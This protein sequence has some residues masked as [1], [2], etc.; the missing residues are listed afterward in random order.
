MKISKP[1]FLLAGAGLGLTL[2]YSQQSSSDNSTKAQQI[3]RQ[4][5]AELN[6]PSSAPA[7]TPPGSLSPEARAKAQKILDE[8]LHQAANGQKP[9]APAPNTEAQSKAEQALQQKLNELR[10]GTASRPET[11]ADAQQIL[12]QK[13]AELNSAPQPAAAPPVSPAPV[14]KAKPAPAP[15]PA[16]PQIA[17]TVQPKPVEPQKTVAVQPK[18]APPK[19]AVTV[20]AKPAVVQVRP[21]PVV[22]QPPPEKTAEV[23]VAEKIDSVPSTPAPTLTPELDAKAREVLRMK[24][25]ESRAQ[26]PAQVEQPAPG[27][28]AAAQAA[29]NQNEAELKAGV[30]PDTTEQTRI[31]R[32][33]IAE[34][35]GIISHEEAT[36][37]SAPVVSAARATPAVGASPVMFQSSNKVG[38]ARLNELTELYKADRI[39]PAEYHHERAKI[40]ASL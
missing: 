19:K 2:V 34:S 28:Q 22:S 23:K 24:I 25:A 32:L 31:L 18:P 36:T 20:Q 11:T 4:K 14:V 9:A 16:E 38:L 6:N 29:L 27:A 12:R 17:V 13:I 21:A 33:K 3:L 39:T 40:V 10:A 7:S 1:V 26:A 35:R 5:I 15:K 37:S 30:T 8:K